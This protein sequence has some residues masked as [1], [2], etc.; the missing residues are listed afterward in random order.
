MITAVYVPPITDT[1]VKGKEKASLDPSKDLSALLPLLPLMP[2][3]IHKLIVPYVVD[4]NLAEEATVDNTI[5]KDES[6]PWSV[7]M[8]EVDTR[9]QRLHFSDPINNPSLP[10]FVQK[11]QGEVRKIAVYRE[12]AKKT[13]EC[14]SDPECLQQIQQFLKL[15]KALEDRDKNM[16][17]ITQRRV[18]VVKTSGGFKYLDGRITDSLRNEKQLTFDGRRVCWN[19]SAISFHRQ[20]F[21]SHACT[22]FLDVALGPEGILFV[23]KKFELEVWTRGWLRKPEKDSI[24]LIGYGLLYRLNYRFDKITWDYERGCLIGEMNGV[25]TE[26]RFD[27]FEAKVM[28]KATPF[29]NLGA[30]IACSAKKCF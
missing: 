7:R 13:S 22:P 19:T 14:F 28:S 18:S 27:S 10:G 21:P 17:C 24:F 23:A 4:Q 15:K 3:D 8:R 16:R 1:L 5:L 26:L 2:I 20:N 12:V 6:K 25:V 30:K 9:H 29:N 11:C